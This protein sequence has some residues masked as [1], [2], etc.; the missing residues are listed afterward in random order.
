MNKKYLVGVSGGCDSIALLDMLYKEGKHLIVCHINYKFRKTS[1]RDQKIV[2]EHCK[3]RKIKFNLLVPLPYTKKDGNF[4]N[5]ARTIRYEYFREIYQKNDCTSLFIGHHRD[6]LIE[7][8]HL[9]K[10]RNID[11]EYYGLKKENYLYDMKVVRPLL[12]WSR[13]EIEKYCLEN[14]LL[15]GE[16]ETNWDLNYKRNKYR[17]Q[18]LKN[19]NEEDKNNIIKEINKENIKK[20]AEKLRIDKLRQLCIKNNKLD[21]NKFI[22]FAEKDQIQI[23]YDF[24]ISNFKKK[25]S[26][27]KRRLK[28]LLK[29]IISDKPNIVLWVENN[30]SL[31]KEYDFLSFNKKSKEYKYLLDENIKEFKC[32][33]F[34]LQL[35]GENKDVVIL[36][37]E[38][39]PITIRNA[40][41]SDKKVNRIFIKNKITFKEREEWPVIINKNGLLLLVLG[42][43]MSY[44]KKAV[45]EEN[46][47]KFYIKRK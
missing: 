28:D 35:K 18:I 21:L 46:I 26:I 32:N 34:D 40:Q 5:W 6:D 14:E 23:L 24:I 12:H 41:K 31:C 4:E 16:D 3:K 42:L 17:H 45:N 2:E 25:L 30:L 33:Q 43:D 38:D 19:M 9:Q 15:Y 47:I 7:T 10:S 22:L 1:D 37:K 39:F 27:S 20:K 29:K 11:C 13:S 8:Y 44:N 36:K